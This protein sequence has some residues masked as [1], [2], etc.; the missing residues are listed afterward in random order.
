V[1]AVLQCDGDCL[2]TVGLKEEEDNVRRATA[3]S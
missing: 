1:A 2:E 3:K